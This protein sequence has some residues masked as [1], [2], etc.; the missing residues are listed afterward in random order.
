MNIRK[1]HQIEKS[2]FTLIELLVVISIIAILAGMLLPALKTSRNAAKNIQCTNQLKQFATVCTSYASDYNGWAPCGLGSANYLFTTTS[3]Y[4][5]V[6]D[7]LGLSGKYYEWGKVAPPV[8]IC[9]FG[10]NDGT[11][12]PTRQDA[13]Y[14]N[15]SYGI[16][17]YLGAYPDEP[18]YN[19]STYNVRNPSQRMMVSEIGVDG[20]NSLVPGSGT[21]VQWR[22]VISFKHNRKVNVGF[23]DCHI[24][25]PDFGKIPYSSSAAYDLNDF[26][27]QH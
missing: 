6:A 7:Y 25:M 13:A 18:S 26:Y 10:G 21:S 17:R 22:G 20:W 16:N 2:T 8:S 24:T 27:R 11:L 15:F 14:P 1:K 4:G 19:Q 9:P 3:A 5:G 23:V 12:N